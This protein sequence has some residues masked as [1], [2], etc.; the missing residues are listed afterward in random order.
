MSAI[1]AV[2]FFE[3]NLCPPAAILTACEEHRSL[4]I[5]YEAPQPC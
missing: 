3:K 1:T 5:K 4:N 2:F